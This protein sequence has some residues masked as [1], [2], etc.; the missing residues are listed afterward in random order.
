MVLFL[1]VSIIVV[2]FVLGVTFV[3]RYFVE[4]PTIDPAEHE[5]LKTDLAAA[6]TVE[7]ELR[8][9]ISVSMKESEAAKKELDDAKSALEE[10]NK[11]QEQV[12]TFKAIEEKYQQNIASLEEQL[13]AIYVKADNQAKEALAIIENLRKPAA[14]APVAAVLPSAGDTKALEDLK[15][16]NQILKNQLEALKDSAARAPIQPVPESTSEPAAAVP[17]EAPP[18]KEMEEKLTQAN[19]A[20]EA[21]KAENETLKI[22]L[23]TP[24]PAASA[25][26]VVSTPTPS[27]P[28]PEVQQELEKSK[29]ENVVLQN[30]LQEEAAKIKQLEDELQQAKASSAKPSLVHV[31]QQENELKKLCDDFKTQLDEMRKTVSQLKLENEQLEARS[32]VTPPDLQERLNKLKEMNTVLMQR[33]KS[34]QLELTKSRVRAIGLERICEDFKAQLDIMAK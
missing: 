26:P 30:R 11:I 7:G 28:S 2:S 13:N 32:T 31:E 8:A 18:S 12:S 17:A 20:L 9:G 24:A 33:E 14:P 22:Q 23:Q 19:A 16:E 4:A 21:L 29:Q 3:F 5:K 25:E 10:A 6:K 1:L 27:I 34:W 15:I